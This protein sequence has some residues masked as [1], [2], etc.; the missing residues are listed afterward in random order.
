[1]THLVLVGG[2][3]AH[4]QVLAALARSRPLGLDVTLV[5][6][7]RRQIYSGMLPGWIVGA[8][9]L[10]EC[11]LPID[12]LARDAGVRFVQAA[13]T[14]LDPDACM[15]E[16]DN[17]E[18]LS[19]DWLSL[20]V[21]SATSCADIDGAPEHLA[22]VRPIERFIATIQAVFDRAASGRPDPVLF[23]GG[24][25]AGVELAFALAWRLGAMGVDVRG[26]ALIRVVGSDAR[27]LA[28]LPGIVRWRAGRLMHAQG[29]EWL[30]GRR[31]V[32]VD[33]N[34]ARLD[35]GRRLDARQVL[36][37]SGAAA[38]AWVARSGLATDAQGF[39]QVSPK[40]QSLSHPRVFAAGDCAAYAST[41]PKSGVF[42]VRA[43]PVLAINLVRAVAGDPLDDWTPQ[44]R[45]LYLIS[46]G[47]GHAL[48]AWGG[49]GWWGDWVW[50]WKDRIDRE[51]MRRFGRNGAGE[52]VRDQ[53]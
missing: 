50:R 31:V 26:K 2:G 4:V 19:F 5:A 51:F 40:L 27:P 30:G 43:G 46:T 41:R 7:F 37:V 36:L 24:G 8:Y 53:T 9:S 29:V 34:G 45:A 11:A 32:A 1:M 6:P 38:H 10:D 13:C 42:A 17:G 48:A 35:D 28:G 22:P 33:A 18:R 52:Q 16:C 12:A 47:R 23:V 20:D 49:V 44:R 39:V 3:H 14:R 15:I 25:A 21:G